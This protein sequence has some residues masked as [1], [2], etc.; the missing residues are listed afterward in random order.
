MIKAFALFTGSAT[1]EIFSCYVVCLWLRL[2]RPVW[3]LVPGALELGL[4]A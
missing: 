1:A 2:Q 4:F 3:W